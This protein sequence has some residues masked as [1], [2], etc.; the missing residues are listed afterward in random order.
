ML[1]A[2]FAFVLLLQAS[3]T[4]L[5]LKEAVRDFPRSQLQLKAGSIPINVNQDSRAAYE[6]LA[7]MA[8]VAVI[9]DPDFRTSA[10]APFR[11]ENGDVL[12][13]LDRLS[14][15]T[16]NFVEVLDSKM[17]LVAG[18]NATV[19]RRHEIQVLKTFYL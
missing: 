9:F 15:L 13:A 7:E 18:N 19:R 12:E 4:P 16:G 11:V 14:L 8:G 5:R 1:Q 2:L 17:I 6:A 10:F 3:P